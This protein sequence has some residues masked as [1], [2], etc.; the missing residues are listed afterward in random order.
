MVEEEIA[1][2]AEKAV[3]E[4][5][6]AEIGEIEGALREAQD[7]LSRSQH[8]ENGDGE[9]DGVLDALSRVHRLHGAVVPGADAL[10][11]E[12]EEDEEE[13]GGVTSG[14]EDDAPR[15]ALGL[16][17]A[18]ANVILLDEAP[19][20][21]NASGVAAGMLAPAM[22]SALDPVSAG[23][24]GL[25]GAARDLW[26]AF[27]EDLG[28]TGLDRCGAL[29]KAES[30]GPS[31]ARYSFAEFH[32]RGAIVWQFEFIRPAETWKLHAY[33]WGPLRMDSAQAGD[34]LAPTGG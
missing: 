33:T 11:E 19:L 4:A 15:T 2:V 24:F 22:E 17:R 7:A 9:G 8:E 34:L 6:L 1:W 18:G 30:A 13:D 28:P 31:I 23:R 21:R 3:K 5:R 16:A 32:T 26:P 14:G 20:G 12:G 25:L 29:L 27:V 10:A